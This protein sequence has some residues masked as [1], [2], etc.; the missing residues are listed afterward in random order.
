[1]AV[2][3][4]VALNGLRVESEAEVDSSNDILVHKPSDTHVYP[5]VAPQR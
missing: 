4:S 5:G 1:L 3:L 2:D